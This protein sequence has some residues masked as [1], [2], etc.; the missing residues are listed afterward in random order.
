MGIDDEISAFRCWTISMYILK[1]IPASCTSD[2]AT[3]CNFSYSNLQ[4]YLCSY[5]H[6]P[7][8]I[9]VIIVLQLIMCIIIMLAT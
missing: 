8:Y 6:R 4:V 3:Y 1:T 9:I 7:V 2:H 5:K